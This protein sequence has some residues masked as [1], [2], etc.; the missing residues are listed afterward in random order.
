MAIFAGAPGIF[1]KI[2]LTAPPATVAVYTAPSKISPVMASMWKVKG[3]S[4]ATAMVGLSPGSAPMIN[5]PA[6]P[7]HSARKLSGVKTLPK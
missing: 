7:A 4:R 2:A 3:M 1:S 5:P 6:V